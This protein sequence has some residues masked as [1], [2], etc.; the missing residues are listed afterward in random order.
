MRDK[1]RRDRLTEWLKQLDDV[2]ATGNWFE[3]DA[4]N[5]RELAS[6][7]RSEIDNNSTLARLLERIRP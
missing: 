7:I 4:D 6:L 2:A 3:I 1:T 5:S